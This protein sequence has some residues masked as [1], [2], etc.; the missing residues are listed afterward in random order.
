[1]SRTARTVL[2]LATGGTFDKGYNVVEEAMLFQD[3]IV[4]DV[5][6]T[7]MVEDYDCR[8]VMMKDSLEMIPSDRAAILKAVS[9]SGQTRVLIVHGTSTMLE[10]AEYLSERLP[11]EFTVVLTG[12][13]KPYRYEATEA[14]SNL[15][16]AVCAAR[17]FTPGVFVAM[18]GLVEIHARVIKDADTGRFRLRDRPAK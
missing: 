11:S 5:L 8:V 9:D 3:S 17:Y 10:T 12:A 15:G 14:A 2:V 4:E 7:A 13:L 18:H 6:R 16:A 1:M